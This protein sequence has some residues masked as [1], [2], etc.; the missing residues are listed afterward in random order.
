LAG[1]IYANCYFC[2][3]AAL[4]LFTRM[5]RQMLFGCNRAGWLQCSA[6]WF[7]RQCCLV[8]TVLAGCN[9]AAWL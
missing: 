5:R 9:D 1:I 6:V 4:A 7:A 2:Q 8:A 3:L